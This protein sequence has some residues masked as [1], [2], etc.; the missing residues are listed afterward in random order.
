MTDRARIEAINAT[1]HTLI[2][3]IE[4]ASHEATLPDQSKITR[5][6]HAADARLAEMVMHMQSAAGLPQ[7]VNPALAEIHSIIA[8]TIRDVQ[9]EIEAMGTVG[10]VENIEDIEP[11]LLDH[12]MRKQAL[13]TA[14]SR[15]NEFLLHM[16]R[17]L[18]GLKA[19]AD[20]PGYGGSD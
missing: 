9:R 6:L 15:A 11:M 17:A 19:S 16:S 7:R 1:V 13:F 12:E 18:Q 5:K 20:A 2:T 14:Q 3:D 4:R 8:T 10:E